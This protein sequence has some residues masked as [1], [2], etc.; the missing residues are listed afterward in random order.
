MEAEEARLSQRLEEMRAEKVALGRIVSRLRRPAA[1]AT[2]QK[3]RVRVPVSITEIVG[4]SIEEA[5]AH[6]AEKNRG[7]FKFT[8]ARRAMVSAGIV[9]EGNRGSTA[10]YRVMSESTLFRKGSMRGEYELIEEDGDGKKE[11]AEPTS[12][13]PHSTSVSTRYSPPREAAV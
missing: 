2:T 4:M 8:A 11:T 3:R 1:A 5:A 9:P 13:F 10:V 6:I 12:P 7:I